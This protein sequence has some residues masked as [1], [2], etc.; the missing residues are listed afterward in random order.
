MS[1]SVRQIA[2]GR[3]GDARGHP[4]SS[5]SFKTR[6]NRILAVGFLVALGLCLPLTYVAT[7][8]VFT[9]VRGS[10]PSGALPNEQKLTASLY[11]LG[12]V[13]VGLIC[14]FAVIYVIAGPTL[15]RPADRLQ[16][17]EARLK[18]SEARAGQLALV[19]KRTS[20][21]VIIYDA[22]GDILWVNAAFEKTTGYS[23]VEVQGRKPSEFLN[24]CGTDIAVSD[25]IAAAIAAGA[26]LTTQ[27]VNYSKTGREYLVEL[28]ITPVHDQNGTLTNFIAVE[29]DITD[30]QNAERR[31]EE[32]LQALKAPICIYNRNEELVACNDA[33]STMVEQFGVSPNLGIEFS[34]I[35]GQTVRNGMLTR[36]D[37]SSDQII[38]NRLNEWRKADGVERVV[39]HGDGR[40]V[41]LRDTRTASGDYVSVRSDVTDLIETQKKAEAAAHSKS[42]F[43]ANVSH[44]IRT[45]MTGVISM[46]ELL[47]TS[48]LNEEQRAGLE[49][50]VQSGDA[51]LTIINDILDFSKIEAGKMSIRPSP[52]DVIE[53]TEDVCALLSASA[54]AKG[55]QYSFRFDP[56][57][58]RNVI[59]DMGRYRQIITNLVGNAIKFTE[60]GHVT[61][62]LGGKP[63]QAL[64]G[65]AQ[66]W[67][68][69]AD[70]G[71]GVSKADLSSIFGA[72]E[73]A[74]AADSKRLQEGT[75]LGLSISR[76]L[77][78]MMDG[79]LTAVSKLNAG[80]VFRLDM[81]SPLDAAAK[82]A[83]QPLTGRNI[84]VV[85]PEVQTAALAD[86][87]TLLGAK[88]EHLTTFDASEDTDLY[89]LILGKETPPLSPALSDCNAPVIIIADQQSSLSADFL[90][91]FQPGKARLIR[92][93]VRTGLL[94]Q[95]CASFVGSEPDTHTR[96]HERR[97]RPR[98]RDAPL[99]LVAEDSSV[100]VMILKALLVDQGYRIMVCPSA[101]SAVA[102]FI[103]NQPAVVIMDL[104]LP[105]MSGVEATRRIRAIETMEDRTRI[106]IIA[107]TADSSEN[108]RHDF[109]EAGASDFMLKPFRANHVRARM[110][111]WA[112]VVSGSEQSSVGIQGS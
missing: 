22:N 108:V 86:Q 4:G 60:S 21:L 77:A 51:L 9:E 12:A 87:L 36:G 8:I 11:I 64:S 56:D 80:S 103:T 13:F 62:R 68:E 34:D 61:I 52:F 98:G 110:R 18:D 38:R 55:L 88:F 35:L 58:P 27:I 112:P 32:A 1:I 81:T 75:G 42:R 109:T 26:P 54:E 10:S 7:S 72:F 95:A 90:S 73:Q 69:V 41:L 100:N 63:K 39:T 23:R 33:Y 19:A 82:P 40:T 93:P 25:R 79:E 104:N 49:L 94:S 67:V 111:H 46:A 76:Q 66:I 5:F 28:S 53:A 105:D 43:L 85:G 45:P 3:S 70:T 71:I 107:A 92:G 57:M 99:I 24:G 30:R 97:R 74:S 96:Q 89:I 6:I 59:G 101:E 20:D 2:T 37:Q 15:R 47:L 14:A 83:L 78:Q 50:I 31:L 102:S 65:A 44:E 48:K 106:P 91:A 17:S 16:R 84:S 29:R